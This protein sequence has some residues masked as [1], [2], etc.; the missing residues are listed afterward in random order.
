MLELTLRLVVSL[1]I[2][3][4]LLLLLAR[5]GARK[6]RGNAGA[7]V[8]VV[9]RQPLSRTSAVAVVTVG[10]RVLVLGTTEQ[11]ISV[12]AELDPEEIELEDAAV[13]SFAEVPD[14]DLV[15]TLRADLP[16]GSLSASALPRTARGSH[17]AAPAASLPSTGPLAGSVL[18]AQTWRQAFQVATGRGSTRRVS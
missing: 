18:S 2:V 4:G 14:A 12:L 3:V 1:A 5:F 7:M 17:R 10:S 9:H 16:A 13:L 6:F 11:Q 8:Q 15:E